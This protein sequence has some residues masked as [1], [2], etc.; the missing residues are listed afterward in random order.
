MLYCCRKTTFSVR[1]RYRACGSLLLLGLSLFVSRPADAQLIYPPPP[2]ATPTNTPY[3]SLV[4][5]PKDPPGPVITDA[6]LGATVNDAFGTQPYFG[7]GV[8]GPDFG[9]Q[10]D[11][12]ITFINASESSQNIDILEIMFDAPYSNIAFDTFE[13][14]D[15]LQNFVLD[16]S[17]NLIPTFDVTATSTPLGNGLF[18]WDVKFTQANGF[19]WKSVTDELGPGTPYFDL[20]GGQF[21]EN[22]NVMFSY[23]AFAPEPGTVAILTALLTVGGSVGWRR[24]RRRR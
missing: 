21:Q 2:P 3:L 14:T 5:R 6:G 13:R 18:H 22:D 9:T 10:P 11:F 23:A 24:I 1:T 7:Q 17:E 19:L 4:P 16:D 12:G 20:L 15:D 8:L